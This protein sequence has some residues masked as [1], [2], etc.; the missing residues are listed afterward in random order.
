MLLRTLPTKGA[1]E[2]PDEFADVVE[3]RRY[4]GFI[5]IAETN[6][7]QALATLSVMRDGYAADVAKN[8][9]AGALTVAEAIAAYEAGRSIGA[10]F[11]LTGWADC[12]AAAGMPNI[13]RLRADLDRGQR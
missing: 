8:W 7:A 9:R 2:L 1:P 6:V 5:E 3:Y 11:R 13:Q 4:A 10:E 12:W